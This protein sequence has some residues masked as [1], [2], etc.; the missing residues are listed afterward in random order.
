MLYCPE[1]VSASVYLMLSCYVVML[2]Y[3]MPPIHPVPYWTLDKYLSLC[4]ICSSAMH[5]ATDTTFA[6][7]NLLL[8]YNVCLH[9]CLYVC[10]NVDASMPWC[11]DGG[12][13]I[14]WDV[15]PWNSPHSR[16]SL[17]FITVSIRLAGLWASGNSLSLALSLLWDHCDYRY[18]H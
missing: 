9:M 17:M 16:H 14:T 2:Y 18:S 5:L 11:S 6:C 7:I 1:L 8:F 15:D 4:V 12:Q 13:K 3:G 10:V